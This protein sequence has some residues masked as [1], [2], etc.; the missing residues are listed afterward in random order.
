MRLKKALLVAYGGGHINMILPVAR[1]LA[2]QGVEVNILALTTA[3]P[4]ALASGFSV[5][6]FLDVLDP[7][8][9]EAALAWGR[10]LAAE[11]DHSSVVAAE[12]TVAYLG[13]S[14]ADLVERLGPEEAQAAYQSLGRQSFLPV[15]VL[16][17][18]L[19]RLQPDVVVATSA[20]RA[21]RAAL[22]AAC[23]RGIPTVYI[24]DLF[25]IRET[26]GL[27]SADFITKICVLSDGVKERLV[28]AGCSEADIY[29]TGNPAFDVLAERRD[30]FDRRAWRAN[31]GWAE[32][33]K[34]ILWASQP[35]PKVHPFNGTAGFPE[36][37]RIVDRVLQDALL[38]HPDWRLVFRAHPSE[39]H[40]WGELPDRVEV[41]SRND[42]L[43]ALLLGVDCVLT[44]SSTIGLE[45]ALVG[46]PVVQLQC[47]IFS[48]DLPLADM[49]FAIEAPTL[50]QLDSALNLA[51][52]GSTVQNESTLYCGGAAKR[53]ASVIQGLL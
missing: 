32:G 51:L 5:L 49:Q 27:V 36:L 39:N 21:E 9:D 44:M 8:Q 43:A 7:A 11:L 28:R 52:E 19:N 17:R 46:T 31:R 20:P 13:L 41:S 34:V 22:I 1:E 4:A 40:V 30:S 12:E 42:D 48:R 25:A 2:A 33:D 18:F 16:E 6:G 47:S 37:P 38:S 45:A 35:E 26:P 15:T 10:E 29:V 24:S 23:R 50:M 53:V 3:R 14:Y